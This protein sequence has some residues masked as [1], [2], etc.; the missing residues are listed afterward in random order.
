ML[1][2]KLMYQGLS[3]PKQEIARR[4]GSAGVGQSTDPGV[5]QKPSRGN[6]FGEQM[7]VS[8]QP[9]ES[10]NQNVPTLSS[11]MLKVEKVT[12]YNFHTWKV[13]MGLAAINA[14]CYAAF[15]QPRPNTYETAAAMTLLLNGTPEL[16]HTS[17]SK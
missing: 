3:V 14:K 6:P 10:G 12:K 11:Q 8:F 9:P 7:Q 13:R 4:E 16:W 2:R 1:E 15:E 5:T 17:L